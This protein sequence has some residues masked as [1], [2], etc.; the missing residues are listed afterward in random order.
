MSM[1]VPFLSDADIEAEADMLLH[2]FEQKHGAIQTV[3]TPLD[4]IIENHL[5]LAFEVVDMG[6]PG[7]LGQLDIEANLIKI[8]RLLDPHDN[9]RMEGR[10]N[11]TLAHECGHQVLHRAYAEE[12]MAPSLFDIAEK[13]EKII[14]CRQEEKKAPIE[15]QADK[16]AS[17]L[18]LPKN[19]VI[20]EFFEYNRGKSIE[21]APLIQILKYDRKFLSQCFHPLHVPTDEEILRHAFKEMA[22]KFHVS[23]QAIVIRLRVLGLLKD[24]KQTEMAY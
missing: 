15:I 9:P 22:E 8:N 5:G 13:K 19:K 14:L 6:H 21:A 24:T 4:E 16:F 2:S 23:M 3:A 17:A 18:L 10:Y 7:I 11:Y 20:A 12:L 1:E